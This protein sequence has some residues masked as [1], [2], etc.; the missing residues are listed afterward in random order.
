M[1]LHYIY[2]ARNVNVGLPEEIPSS[3]IVIP[4]PALFNPLD[5]QEWRFEK[6]FPI[7]MV[8]KPSREEHSNNPPSADYFSLSDIGFRWIPCFHPRVPAP[9][10]NIDTLKAEGSQF[11]CHPGTGRFP[12][13]GAVCYD[14]PVFGEQSSPTT[15]AARIFSHGFLCFAPTHFPGHV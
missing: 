4:T 7:S 12:R 8:T 6:G 2:R 14:D 3:G 9:F 5:H 13:S 1:K 10:E 15:D 11:T